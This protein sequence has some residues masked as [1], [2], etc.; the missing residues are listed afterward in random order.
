MTSVEEIQQMQLLLRQEKESERKHYEELM[1]KSSLKERIASGLC[2]Y[3]LN[4]LEQG[5]GLGSQPFIV[6]ERSKQLEQRHRFKAGQP[7]FVFSE[8]F[9]NKGEVLQEKGIIH[10]VSKNRMKIILYNKDF[11]SWIMRNSIGVQLEF[12]ERSYLEM[13]KALEAVEAAAPGS[14]LAD[15]REILLGY[16]EPGFKKLNREYDFEQLNSSQREAIKQVLSAHDVA[17]IHGPPGTGKTTTIVRAVQELAKREGPILVCA[18]SNAATDLLTERLAEKKLSVVRIGNISRVDE[19]LLEHTVDGILDKRPEMQDVKNMKKEADKL[20][21]QAD[22][23]RRSFGHAEREERR[24]QRQ[25]AKDLLAQARMLE[26]YVV[27]RIISEADAICSTLVSSTSE[28]IAK[29]E[30]AVLIVDEAA[31]ALAPATWIPILR[32]KK[33]ILAGDPQQLPPTVKNL[34]AAKKGLNKS[35]LETVVERLPNAV[36]LLKEQYRMNEKIMEFSN[37][38]FYQGQLKA[39]PYVAKWVLDLADGLDQKPLEWIDT[40]GCGFEEEQNPETMSYANPEE[41]K[42]LRLHLDNLLCRL[43]EQRPSIAIVSPY[44]E[45]VR[46]IQEQIES[47]FEHFP[48]ADIQVDT[49]DSFQGQERDVIYISLVRSNDKGEIGFLKDTRRMNVAM[50]RARK[51][52]IMIGDSATLGGFPFYEQLLSYCEEIDAYGSAWEWI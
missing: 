13:E 51:K 23:F 36:S 15:L 25:E 28:Y 5:W 26:D 27:E 43:G 30:F 31:Q 47:D 38:I 49:I 9:I 45:Q 35:L 1:R 50:T 29:R 46:A 39:S 14:R 21:R 11:P 6:V 17:A 24:Q 22:K 3:P 41:Y 34:D 8:Q 44:K 40:A 32:S 4:K 19:S 33:I 7:V 18:A 20:F 48:D 52:L 37:R 42:V 2:W 10:Y 16:R 12:D